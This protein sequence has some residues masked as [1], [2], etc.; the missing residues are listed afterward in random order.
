VYIVARA[1][2][3]LYI[4]VPFCAGACDYCDFYSLPAGAGD[5]RLDRYLDLLLG[6]AESLLGEGAWDIPA[7][8]IGG[9]T[10]SL[11]GASGIG[12]LLRGLGGLWSGAPP[13][14]ITVEA[15]PESAGYDF[16][17]SCGENGV[18]RLSLGIQSFHP[19]SRRAVRRVG[20][21]EALHQALAR[22]GEVFPGAFS[23]DLIT[24]LPFQDEGAALRDLEQLLAYNPAHV[25]LYALTVEEE[26]PV[27]IGP[28]PPADR[29]DRL[30]LLARDVLEAAGYGQYEISNFSLPGKESIHNIRYWR[31]E[32]WLALGPSASATII[33]D[34]RGEALRYTVPPDL[35]AWLNRSPG[36]AAP[37]L[38]ES[39]DSLTLMKETFLMGFRSIRGPDTALFRKRF[40]RSLGETIPRTM[41]LLEK[42]GLL[43]DNSPERAALNREGLALLNSFL[44]D[45]FDEA[46]K[47]FPGPGKGWTKR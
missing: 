8:Y 44:P 46:E 4:H 22:A 19:P 36:T 7:A 27:K 30:W 35:D 10:P 25:S 38:E 9:G 3:S 42:R 5:D 6:D 2:A 1:E 23:G 31:M 37:R 28:L 26:S 47:N 14:E 13:R 43:R 29:A 24:G 17:R 40:R 34:E 11:L 41:A 16:L 12:R 18:T 33:D 21:E 32:S 39:L 20:G 15:N 45:M